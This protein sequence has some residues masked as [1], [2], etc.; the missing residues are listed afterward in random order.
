MSGPCDPR[1]RRV[2]LQTESHTFGMVALAVVWLAASAIA[3]AQEPGDPSPD[4]SRPAKR[5]T[6]SNQS[7]SIDSPP[8]DVP[9]TPVEADASSEGQTAGS[10][11]PGAGLSEAST[12]IPRPIIRRR[13]AG[14]SE[15]TLLGE[16]STPWF[17]TGIGALSI[18]LVLVG[19]IYF[20]ARRYVPSI[21]AS[22]GGVLRVVTR[23]SLTSKQTLALI[24][25]G[26]RCVMV[27]ISP[28]R[29][30]VLSEITDPDEVADLTARTGAAGTGG[31]Q[32][33]DSLLSHEAKAF[34]VPEHTDQSTR[35][36]SSGPVAD[37]LTRLRSLQRSH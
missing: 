9:T 12:A 13:P 25:L 8:S 31:A 7:V 34:D 17:R 4:V 37:L 30:D 1:A 27:A 3:P 19:L 21:R 24:Q 28:N 6:T 36:R 18:V 11:A 14:E 20:L 32:P 26:R 16:R 33:F 23:T 5:H 29:V 10:P 35:R 15:E 22:D 2:S